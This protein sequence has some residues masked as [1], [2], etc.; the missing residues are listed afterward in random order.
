MKCGRSWLDGP[1][2]QAAATRRVKHRVP[3]AVIGGGFFTQPV[4]FSEGRPCPSPAFGHKHEWAMGARHG[5]F[6][7]N[8]GSSTGRSARHNG[9][10]D[11]KGLLAPITR[12]WRDASYRGGCG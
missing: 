3:T 12:R 10:P 1:V 4:S 2:Q 9:R 5:S 7:L 11:D 8:C 6:A